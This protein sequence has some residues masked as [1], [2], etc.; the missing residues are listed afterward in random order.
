MNTKDSTETLASSAVE[1]KLLA[2][3]VEVQPVKTYGIGIDCHSKFIQVCVLARLDQKF[4]AHQKEFNTDWNSLIEAK[5]WVC[6]VLKEATKP[7]VDI[8]LPLHYCIESTSTYHMPILLAW[9]GAPS[10]VNPTIAGATKRKTDVLDAKLLA[11]HDLIGVWRESYLPSTEI[12]EL[13]LLV[14]ER[15]RCISEANVASRRINNSVVRFGLTVGRKGSVTKDKDVRSIVMNQISDDPNY[16][17]NVCPIGIPDDVKQ[18]I[19]ANYDKY[20]SLTTQAEAWRNQILSKVYSMEWETDTSLLSGQE[21]LQLLTT[22]PQVGELTAVTWLV[23]I[24]TPRR[25]SNSKAIAAYCGLDPSLKISAKHITST[26]KRGGN[27]DLHYALTSAVDRLIRNHTEMFG[28]WGFN[29]YRQTGKWNKAANA[30]ARK[31]CVSL[32]YMMKTGQTFSYEKYNLV[33]NL[34]TFDIPVEYLPAL[35]PDF[36]RYI[37]ILHEHDI[38]TTADMV[39]AYLSCKLGSYRGLGKKYFITLRDFLNHQ[40]KYKE[41]YLNLEL[42]RSSQ[43]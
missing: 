38:D 9:E 24:I 23:H 8:S 12:K 4:Y 21:M 29:L 41:L 33:K 5:I 11:T 22:A 27:K 39:T 15:D 2:K 14:A 7:Q 13:R 30:V 1:T 10:I 40:H 35:N 36:K 28:Q 6:T 25:F 3:G 17:V 43:T 37:R 31:L 42:E 32:F 34:D 19:R 16:D 26:R 20:D 18:I